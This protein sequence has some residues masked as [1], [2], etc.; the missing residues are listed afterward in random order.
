MKKILLY[1]L[2]ISIGILSFIMIKE[3]LQISLYPL[4]KNYQEKKIIGSLNDYKTINTEHFTIYFKEGEESV[5][6]A[7]GDIIEKH[8]NYVCSS[9]NHYPE[10]KI[11]I[12]IYEKEEDI[13]QS[14]NLDRNQ[15]PPIGVYYSGTINLLS[16]KNWMEE[17]NLIEEYEKINPVVHEFTHLIVD[18]KTKGNYPLWLTE[19]L[20]VFME[21]ATMGIEWNG[22]IGETSD[23][24]LKQLNNNFED[25]EFEIAYRK[26][27]ET[28]VYL[29]SQYEFDNINLLLDNLGIGTNIDTSLKRVFKKNLNGFKN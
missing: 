8:Y 4:I 6:K 11:P 12:I 2:I 26:S 27:Y 1:A 13:I 17:D 5:G 20:A 21:K 16:P 7:T 23:I 28:I 24:T 25:I 19:G 29:D 18:E 15:P 9:F 10:G 14:I 22:G 3:Y